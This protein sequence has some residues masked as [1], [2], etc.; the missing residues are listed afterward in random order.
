PPLSESSAGRTSSPWFS[1]TSCRSSTAANSSRPFQRVKNRFQRSAACE[2][3]EPIRGCLNLV[4]RGASIVL[5]EDLRRAPA[6]ERL[7]D[8][9]R[10]ARTA[11]EIRA[12][13]PETVEA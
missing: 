11:Q 5:Q 8:F 7:D 9:E 1:C 4:F 12:S 3:P 2:I 10:D 13:P 6:S